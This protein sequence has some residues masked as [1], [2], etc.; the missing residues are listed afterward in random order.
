VVSVM[1]QVRYPVRATAYRLLTRRVAPWP[2]MR[3]GFPLWAADDDPAAR[4][5]PDDAPAEPVGEEFPPGRTSWQERARA[6]Q[7]TRARADA[8]APAAEPGRRGLAAIAAV[9]AGGAVA[10]VLALFLIGALDDGTTEI[11]QPEQLES[12][13]GR[14]EPSRTGSIYAGAGKSVVQV[15]RNGGSGTGWVVDGDGTVVTNAHVVGG[16]SE[17]RL[18]L[19]DGKPPVKADVSGTDPSSDLA[20]LRADPDDLDGLKP[21]PLADSDDVKVGDLAIA[22][23]YPLGLQRSVT[24]GIVSGVGRS[25]RALNRFDIDEV[26]QTD[27]PINPGNSGGPLLDARGRVIGVN[28]QIATAGGGGGNV[29]IGFAVPSN[30]VREVVPVLKRGRSVVRPYLGVST[31]ASVTGGPGAVVREVQPDS[32]ASRAGLRPG[33]SLNGTDGDIIVSVDGKPVRAPEDV[34]RAVARREPGDRIPV[35]VLRD[36][37]R[38]TLAV[39]LDRRPEGP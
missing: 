22:I 12:T 25:I 13:P 33:R 32:P 16:A 14:V 31:G 37:D 1:A 39:E 8:P 20:V 10:A 26:I 3:D 9:A 28:S 21:L 5:R 15:R 35:T 7:P 36:G 11:A 34:A 4:P 38:V 19:D 23:G 6:Q 2:W 29:G 18:V 17:V 30:T 27:A 24:Q